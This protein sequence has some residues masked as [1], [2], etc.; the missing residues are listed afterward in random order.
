MSATALSLLL[1]CHAASFDPARGRPY[2]RIEDAAIAF[3]RTGL[4]WVGPRS[5][6]PA[7]LRTAA[8]ETHT[9]DG[10]WVTPGLIDCHT[11]AV[12]GG[13]R[14]DEFALRLGGMSYAD[15]AAAGGGILGTVA[16]TAAA[17]VG[18]LVAAT[19]PRL[20][21][22]AADGVTTVEIKSGYGLT[23]AAE[24]SML[25]AA[26]V[27]A[28][29]AALEVRTTLLGLHALPL[30]ARG[31]AVA[32]AA[33]IAEVTRQ[34]L[35][36]LH[37]EG[38]V[39]AVDA[40]CEGIAFSTAEC[41]QWF[42]AAQALGVPV[43]LHADQLSDGAGAA[44]AARYGALSADHVEYTGESAVQAMAAAGTVA[45]LLPAAFLVLGETRKPPVAVFRRHGVPMAV[46]S[47]LNPGTSPVLSLRLSAALAC[48]QF[49]LT[50]EEA[51]A[52]CTVHAARALG[53][54]DRGILRAGLRAD[55]AVWRVQR[56]EEL[57]YWLGGQLLSARFVGGVLA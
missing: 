38:L 56:I 30:Q 44:L 25:Q 6:L 39:D 45:V 15:I 46:A 55:L 20:R 14:A 42:D 12:F 32:R 28:Q 31:D 5:E 16:K 7:V 57:T 41:A 50:P 17:D 40:F 53:L 26:R 22:L 34:W 2:G 3:D 21:A 18:T 29:Q 54:S 24:R 4:R 11:H 36:A 43:K 48:C 10:A 1:D 35:P 52:G 9:L 27:A 19:L 37:A 51:L 13:D 49:G 23:L 8:T 33:W 47:D